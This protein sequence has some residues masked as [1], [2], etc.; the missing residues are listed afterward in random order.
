M[1]ATTGYHSLFFE[2]LSNRLIGLSG[3]YV[4]DI[5]RA[6]TS[7]FL[8]ISFNTTRETFN[9]KPPENLPLEFTGILISGNLN[10]C[11]VTHERYIARLEQLS[12]SATSDDF[13]SLRAKLS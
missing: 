9:T 8:K 4:D 12:S 5:L 11:H 13:R 2:R 6:G 3:F 7:Y 10:S 1:T